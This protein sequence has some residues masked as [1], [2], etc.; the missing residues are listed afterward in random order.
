MTLD[1]PW[2]DIEIIQKGTS[3]K[4]EVNLLVRPDLWT[5]TRFRVVS[6]NKVQ[7][8]KSVVIEA[9]PVQDPNHWLT[10]SNEEL[11]KHF[12]A[13]RLSKETLSKKRRQR[14]HVRHGHQD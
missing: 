7:L 1:V 10:R 8:S 6:E 9:N 14:K 4:S 2:A 11:G 12:K 5:E 3:D 13:V